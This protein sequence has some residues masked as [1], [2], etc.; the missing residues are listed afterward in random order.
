MGARPCPV[1][2]IHPT[3][4]QNG[5]PLL[6]A[7]IHG[8]RDSHGGGRTRHSHTALG[9]MGTPYEVASLWGG[10]VG[11]EKTGEGGQLE[12]KA[13]L[14]RAPARDSDPVKKRCP[15]KGGAKS[16]AKHDTTDFHTGPEVASGDR[17]GSQ[18]GV[19]GDREA[20][21]P[22]VIPFTPPVTRC[23]TRRPKVRSRLKKSW[24]C[25]RHGHPPCPTRTL[26]HRGVRHCCARG[27]P[28]QS[29]DTCTPC[30]PRL[31]GCLASQR[32]LGEGGTPAAKTHLM[33]SPTTEGM[34]TRTTRPTQQTPSQEGGGGKH[35]REPSPFP[36]VT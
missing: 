2:G 4:G 5:A 30:L 27:H 23:K 31:G 7:D 35:G 33:S 32:T 13:S 17:R 29:R 6:V 12:K 16:A 19:D 8:R 36:Q 24:I 26:T 22:V 20:T 15:A 9:S 25:E 18:F 11:I 28:G 3:G 21:A 14:N 34:P 1:A 10:A